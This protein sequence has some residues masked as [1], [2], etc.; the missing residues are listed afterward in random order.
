MLLMTKRVGCIS[1]SKVAYNGSGIAV[2]WHLEVEI[3]NLKIDIK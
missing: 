2:R 1:F 3:L